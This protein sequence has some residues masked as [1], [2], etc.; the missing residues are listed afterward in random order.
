MHARNPLVG[1]ALGPEEPLTL[2]KAFDAGWEVVRHGYDARNPVSTDVGRL[3]LAD[4]ILAA[5]GS[6]L[7]A[8][9]LITAH[10]LDRLRFRKTG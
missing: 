8:A 9:D 10:A 4:A 1:N 2:Y 5:Y 3:R 6:G 7:V